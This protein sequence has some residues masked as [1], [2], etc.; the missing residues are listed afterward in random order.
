MRATIRDGT[1]LVKM[2]QTTRICTERR[3][4]LADNRLRRPPE[5]PN[6]SSESASS[7]DPRGAT[8]DVRVLTNRRDKT[9]IRCIAARIPH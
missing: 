9:T 1:R 5:P 8:R 3:S 4:A 7:A 2:P 6:E